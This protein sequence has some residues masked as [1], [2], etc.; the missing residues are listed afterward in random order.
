VNEDTQR[1]VTAPAIYDRR[2]PK[3]PRSLTSG[4]LGRFVVC[5]NRLDRRG[6]LATVL[7]RYAAL[8]FGRGNAAVALEYAHEALDWSRKLGLA[9][10]QAQA[11]ALLVRLSSGAGGA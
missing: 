7:V 3:R 11:E 5:A 10:E 4:D 8:R 1:A 2:S 6:Y 9:H